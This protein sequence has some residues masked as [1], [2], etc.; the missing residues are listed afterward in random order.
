MARCASALDL[1]DYAEAA[2][3]AVMVVVVV[4]GRADFQESAVGPLNCIS[5]P[6]PV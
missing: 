5:L 4:R 1:S 3:V 6:P 2:V